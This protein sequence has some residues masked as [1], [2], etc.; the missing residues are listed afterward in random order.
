LLCPTC[1]GDNFSER[2]AFKTVSEPLLGSPSASVVVDIKNCNR[3]G[4]DVPTVRGKR[5]YALLSEKRLS[6]LVADLEEAQR[7]NSEMQGL[8]DTMEKRSQSLL[9]EVE[10]CRADGEMSAIEE[11]ITALEEE[12]EGLDERRARLAEILDMLASRAPAA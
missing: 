12:T 11:K 7:I 9:A 3:C 8:L 4:V 1:S 10:R 2:T 5:Q 6:A